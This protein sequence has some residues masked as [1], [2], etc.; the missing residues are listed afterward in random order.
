MLAAQTR[1][2]IGHRG[3]AM[4]ELMGEVQTGLRRVFGTERPVFVFTSS[5]TGM[6]EAAVRN[7][8]SSRVLSLVNGAFSER[9]ARIAALRGVEVDEIA[10]PWGGH[11]EPES[12]R[13]ELLKRP[14]DAVTV[15]H[16]ETSTGVL[17]P[18]KDLA[19][20]VAEHAE[21]I[22]LVDAV[23]SAAAVELCADAWKLGFVFAGSQKALALPPG[24]SFAAASEAMMRRAAAIPARG[25]YFDLVGAAARLADLEPPTTPAVSLLYA[26]QE[27][28]RRIER[29]TL[30]A[31]WSRHRD[32]A[33]RCWAWV[34]EMRDGKGVQVSVLAAE[35]YRSPAVTCIRLPDG[36]EGPAVVDALAARGWAVG[37]GL[38]ALR[39]STIRIGHMGDHTVDELDEL[40][41]ALAEV[42]G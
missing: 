11:H 15:V 36:K 39:E 7:G 5:A 14:Y 31:R 41:E 25:L 30:A 6:M 33:E 2:M 28:L 12:V 4:H 23:S 13:Y 27:Q 17:N 34:D 9:F 18:L 19:A 42:L 24:L 26:L 29:E 32:M 3:P 35:G 16:S 10:V 38:G 20:V 8:S 1:A 21:V 37:S 40:L 22:L